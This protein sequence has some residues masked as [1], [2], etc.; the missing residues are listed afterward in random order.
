MSQTSGAKPD[1]RKVP[2]DNKSNQRPG[3]VSGEAMKSQGRNLARANLQ[4]RSK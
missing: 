2:V 1:G 3:G 4:K